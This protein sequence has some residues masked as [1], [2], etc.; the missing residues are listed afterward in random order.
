MGVVLCDEARK[1][2]QEWKN[3]KETSKGHRKEE[4]TCDMKQKGAA[5]TMVYVSPLY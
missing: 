4:N 3:Y 1:S 2:S 5:L